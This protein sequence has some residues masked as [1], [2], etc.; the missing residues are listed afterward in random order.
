M[1][2]TNPKP[3]QIRRLVFS[4]SFMVL[5][6]SLRFAL[7]ATLNPTVLLVSDFRLSIVFPRSNHNGGIDFHPA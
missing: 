6:P 7:I 4:I 3:I 2:T 5:P 1:R